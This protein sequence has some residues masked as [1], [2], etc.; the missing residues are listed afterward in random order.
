[1]TKPWVMDRYDRA[2]QKYHATHEELAWE[3]KMNRLAAIRARE[4]RM[5][6]YTPPVQLPLF[7]RVVQPRNVKTEPEALYADVVALR[8]HGAAVYRA[9]RHEHIVDG[10]TVGDAQL[11]A[12]A[13]Q[14]AR[15]A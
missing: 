3:I 5:S 10:R 15:P 4:R 2:S 14:I 6:K 7:G 11:A 13:R 12:M 1:M 9:G 8:K